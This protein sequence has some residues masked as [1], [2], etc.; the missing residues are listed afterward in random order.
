MGQAQARVVGRDAERAALTAALERAADAP[1][2]V[3]ISGEAGI[4]KSRLL[5]DAAETAGEL[6]WRVLVGQCLALS[7]GDLSYAPW[8]QALRQLR[9]SEGRE[10]MARLLGEDAAALA[11][12]VGTAVDEPPPTAHVLEALLSLLERIAEERPV[13][14]G[15]EDLHWADSQ[16]LDALAFL[17]RNLADVPV[18]LV[19]TCRSD[20][21]PDGALPAQL[22]ELRRAPRVTV[23]ELLPLDV[24]TTAALLTALGAD[25]AA[26]GELHARAGGNPYYLTE[27]VAAGPARVHE[28]NDVVL[29]RLDGLSPASRR[30]LEALAVA[31]RPTPQALVERVTGL[32]ATAST[33]A[34]RALRVR[35]LLAT[36]P[37]GGH[38]PA[39]ALAAEA[40]LS[41]L[42]PGQ[43][44]AL[45]SAFAEA[46]EA[47]PALL[48]DPA[49]LPVAL[50]EHRAA[51]PDPAAALAAAAA[52]ARQVTSPRAVLHWGSS[53]LERWP[54]VPDAAA[55]AGCSRGELLALVA[56]ATLRTGDPAGAAARME[57]ALTEPDAADPA[58]GGARGERLAHYLWSAGRS[59]EAAEANTRALELLGD[60]PTTALARAQASYASTLM[61]LGRWRDAE[62]A[63]RSAIATAQR[64]GA[65]AEQAHALATLGVVQVSCGDTAA[66]LAALDEAG[67][68]ARRSGDVR[69][70]WRNLLNAAYAAEV[71][72]RLDDAA[73][74]A[75]E[76]YALAERHGMD[77]SDVRAAIAN[78]VSPLVDRGR[79]DE[80]E[81]LLAAAP[82]GAA[83]DPRV[84][85]LDRVAAEVQVARGL[86]IP[87]GVLDGDEDEPRVRQQR[88]L[89]VAERALWAGDSAAALTAVRAALS[90]DGS[91]VDGLRL[92]AA[93][94]RACA[95]ALAL[96]VAAG[97]P[98][99]QERAA[100]LAQVDAWSADLPDGGEGDMAVL[101]LLARA[102]AARAHGTDVPAQWRAVVS[103]WTDR[104]RPYPAAV[105]AWREAE[106][107]A[108][109]GQS[110][111]AP[112]R[113]A[114]DV[115]LRLRAAPLRRVVELLALRTRTPL[116]TTVSVPAQPAGP[117][118][119]LALTR[120]ERQVLEL[121]A[122]GASNR[123]IGRQLSI[124][125]NTAG[126]H[127]SN[128][129]RKL[130]VANRS[131]A[132][133]VAHRLGLAPNGGGTP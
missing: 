56:E 88:D 105:A 70:T 91:V 92:R 39:H 120:R 63:C 27:L 126:V 82:P 60:E 57:L 130:G 64:V 8:R 14:L 15:L 66:G 78:A 4:G 54:L 38:A 24:A 44:A 104:G 7:G 69:L 113:E 9:R 103:A 61:V 5:G 71:A 111:H 32:D 29:A 52:A 122:T 127:V 46:L 58:V 1:Q 6:G 12:I 3:L 45:H 40:V 125:E 74:R 99:P 117:V 23:V 109:R 124:T 101:V 97:G 21:S 116:L 37:D 128:V 121:L 10:A 33:D 102:E 51:G 123:R 96:P 118:D 31:G 100:L 114:H 36:T 132:T 20:E 18:L 28:L 95:D 72:G 42:L 68:L 112:L 35:R 108:A 22:A 115:A 2:L 17:L 80:A 53:A 119:Q 98:G 133:A 11:P 106:C 83:H 34:L 47:E 59:R 73:E 87:P 81:A 131:E 16:S 77:S 89:L 25:A 129:L 50:A 41:H 62:T 94:L 13:L 48:G 90:T 43:A 65:V 55:L 93:G 49:A 86:D 79:W 19:A 30:V 107:A 75:L 26:A 76:A 85:L 110:P 67:A 84:R